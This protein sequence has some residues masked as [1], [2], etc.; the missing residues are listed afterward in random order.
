[1]PDRR[2]AWSKE[3]TIV[4]FNIYCKIAFS[5]ATKTNPTI[6]S[7]AKLLGRTPSALAMK[8]G[9]LASLDPELKKQGIGGLPNI[10]KLDKEVW[11]EFSR[12]W[13]RLAFESEEALAKLSDSRVEDV[14]ENLT[15]DDD[16]PL[17][18]GLDKQSVVKARVNQA[19]FRSAVMSAYDKKCCITGISVPELLVASHIIPWAKRD[20]TRTDPRNGL[21]LNSIHDKAFDAGL[22]TI[23]QDYTIRVSDYIY[24]FLPNNIIDKW[25]I[26]YT[27]KSIFLPDKF[28]PLKEYLKWHSNNIF[29]GKGI[30]IISK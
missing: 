10:S 13:N 21:L 12:D 15:L 18:R 1:M 24:E 27:G 6:I 2:R 28:L 19:F 23:S 26:D 8:I 7:N 20:D 11:D 17:P 25:F 5:K 14:I 9:N 4:A 16:T 3:E 29:R 22:I 30:D